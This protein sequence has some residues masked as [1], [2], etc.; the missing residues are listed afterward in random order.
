MESVKSKLFSSVRNSIQNISM[1][2]GVAFSG[3]L[4]SSVLLDVIARIAGP[5]EVR[6]IHVCHN[7]RPELELTAEL[8]FVRRICAKRDIPLSV[9]TVPRGSIET[10]A[11]EKKCGIEAAAR[12]FRYHAFSR[13]AKKYGL[14]AIFVA[15]HLDDQIETML[16]R[17][18]HGGS[19]IALSGMRPTR[20]LSVNPDIV[21]LRPFLKTP[22]KNLVRYAESAGL[23]WSEDSTNAEEVYLRNR[24]RKTL[25]PLLDEQFSFWRSAFAHYQAQIEDL[26]EIVLNRAREKRAEI[27]R[28]VDGKRALELTSLRTEPRAVRIEILR[29]F[30]ESLST[31]RPML[32]RG[33]R[34]LE[35]GIAKGAKNIEASGNIFALESQI[36]VFQGPTQFSSSPERRAI[37]EL[38]AALLE[39]IYYLKVPSFGEYSCGPFSVRIAREL[40]DNCARGATEVQGVREFA[41]PVTFPFVIRSRR[42]GDS[43]D[44]GIHGV[45][46]V[47]SM[48]KKAGLP[49]ARRDEVPIVEDAMGIA[50]VLPSALGS[51][52]GARDAFREPSLGESIQIVYI[53]L[54]MKGDQFIN[55]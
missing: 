32:A 19:V 14:L 4:D 15:H 1:P 39:N 30:A 29:Q 35:A 37:A 12:R 26:S 34:H 33:V 40:T 22:K 50:A 21:I 3:G 55:V 48:I 52:A 20:V 6:A 5:N 28:N 8:D 17:L 2:V 44:G 54:S 51:V 41:I 47:E 7:L 11:R 38:D 10:F 16:M 23:R 27:E 31:A 13:I 42:A 18:V 43:L 25:M 9:A 36:L 53:F 45:K 46:N 24:I 49:R